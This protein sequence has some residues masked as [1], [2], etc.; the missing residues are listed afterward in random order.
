MKK[1]I[2]NIFIILDQ[3]EKKNII[4]LIFLDIVI[5]LLDIGFL[6]MLLY[7]IGFYTQQTA[8]PLSFFSKFLNEDYLLLI[9]V[10][11]ILF[12]AKNIFGFHVLQRQLKFVYAVASRLSGQNVMNYLDDSFSNYVS[13]DSSVQ[14]RKISQQP[15][16]FCHYVLTAIQQ[17][18]GQSF[19]ILLTVIAL[20]IYNPLLFLFLFLILTP[21]IILAGF[22]MKRKLNAVRKNAKSLSEKTLQHLKEALSGF[23]ESNIF[24]SKTFFST[25]YRKSQSQFNKV[26]ADQLEIQNM[27]SRLI[28]IFAVMG[29]LLLILIHSFTASSSIS[30]ITIGAFMAAA[31][32]I[33]PGIVKIL[34]S[35]GQIKT[36]EFTVDDLLKNK[37]FISVN[38]SEK[39][40][41]FHSLEFK[42]VSFQFKG[43]PV[44]K[45]V[46]FFVSKGDFVGLSG[47]SG[48]GKTTMMNL[49]L[50][51]LE[52]GEGRILVNGIYVEMEQRQAHWQKVSYVKQQPLLIY[53]SILKNITLNESV[54]DFQKLEEVLRVTGLKE[55]V[56]NFPEGYNKIITEN[57][58]NLSGGQRQRIAIAR[59]LYKDADLIIL[60]EP[61]SELDRHSEDGLL[62][63]FSAL[64]G[65]GKIIILITHNQES[66][67]FC[68]KIISLD[69]NKSA[70]ISDINSRLS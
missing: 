51:F 70:L 53:D 13:I 69:E 50:G 21:A 1:I 48:K 46:S 10:F 56:S 45:H 29:L 22:V 7:V 55:I 62:K 16:E 38:I 3:K 19:L 59:A 52:P 24:Q 8:G 41:S 57:G 27:P 34:N 35:S 68:N 47:I 32:K 60:D 5:S 9:V 43:E 37:P 54:F 12:T 26:L 63:Y 23:I 2:K 39:K 28:E 15:I 25:R 65:Q 20:L 4:E 14:I 33:I 64:S 17:I 44:L 6:V 40:S 30:V 67:L 36:Y 11:F 49:L 58:K 66:L 18:V 31:Y 42:N 61:F